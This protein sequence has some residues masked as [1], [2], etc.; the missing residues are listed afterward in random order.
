MPSSAELWLRKQLR[1][2][3]SLH[4]YNFD[5]VECL[6]VVGKRV[7]LAEYFHVQFG[8]YYGSRGEI[9]ATVI[10]F[11][12]IVFSFCATVVLRVLCVKFRL[13]VISVMLFILFMLLN[14]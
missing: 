11:F 8:R 7:P 4:V 10:A 9:P 12:F 5:L 14:C 1:L 13:N 6:G 2:F 3:L